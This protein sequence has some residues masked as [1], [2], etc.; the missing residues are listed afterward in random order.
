MNFQKKHRRGGMRRNQATLPLRPAMF[1][2]SVNKF[3]LPRAILHFRGNRLI[4]KEEMF[5]V[6]RF[7][8]A[9]DFC[10]SPVRLP[11][12]TSPLAIREEGDAKVSPYAIGMAYRN[13]SGHLAGA[14]G[15]TSPDT[16]HEL[17]LTRIH[18]ATPATPATIRCSIPISESGSWRAACSGPRY[19][20]KGS[21]HL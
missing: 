3:Q 7:P 10:A 1:R 4:P 5:L 8:R 17:N 13:A 6:I 16:S 15:A 2:A 9:G 20:Q 14:G 19:N 11:C 18:P 12:L 21:K